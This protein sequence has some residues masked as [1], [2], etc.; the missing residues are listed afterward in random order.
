M[1]NRP[2]RI[3]LANAFRP[4]QND[5]PTSNT[6]GTRKHRLFSR[7]PRLQL[8]LFPFVRKDGLSGVMLKSCG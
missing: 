3:S 8:E 4:V 2:I 1:S 6:D 7:G 5:L